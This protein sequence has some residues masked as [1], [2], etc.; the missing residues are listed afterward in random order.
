MSSRWLSLLE[1][2]V[3][4]GVLGLAAVCLVAMLWMYLIRSPN[5]VPYGGRELGPRELAEAIKG[6]A[7]SLEKTFRQPAGQPP[8]VEKFSDRLRKQHDQGIF[9]RGAGQEPALAPELRLAS[10]FGREIVVPGLKE[11]EDAS[12]SI[13]LVTP[14]RPSQLKLRTGRSL[15]VCEQVRITGLE[16]PPAPTPPEESVEAEE[17]AW[18]TV[19]A[20][21]DKK[22]QYDEMIRAGYAPYRSKAYVVGVDAQRQEVLSTGEYSDWSDVRS[23]KA[24]PKFEL[25]EPQFDDQTG[26]LLNKNEIRQTFATVKDAQSTLM[27]P[28]FYAVEGGDFWEFPALAGYE[29]EEEEEEEPED[30]DDRF[31]VVR[32]ASP[33]AAAPPARRTST[34]G[35]S[36]T[37]R[38]GGARGG[39]IRVGPGFRGE[40]GGARTGGYTRSEDDAKKEARKQIRED[41]TE[42]K[43]YLGQKEYD[44]AAQ[45]ANRVIDSQYATKGNIRRAQEILKAA[46]RWLKLQAERE[47]GG[48]GLAR[49]AGVR[50]MPASGGETVE[51][52]AHPETGAPAVW[53][54]DD[55]VEAGKTYRYRMRVKLWNRYVG[56][57][58]A[59]QDPEDAKRTVV[60]GKWSYPSEPVTVTPNT[61]FFFSGGRPPDSASTD[62][63][64]WLKGRWFK[65][66]FD[67]SIGDVIGDMRKI[68]TGEYD[69]EGDE[70]RT[71][72]DFTT[73]VVVLDL[74][75]DER[76]D[77]RWPGKDGRFSYRD[78][79]STVMV[80][81]DP[82]DGQVKEK[83]LIFDRS[84]PK[85]KELEDEAW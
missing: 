72:V 14:L 84:N 24:M 45:T 31:A 64:K 61:Y 70:I 47:E 20:Y 9:A 37:G 76:I 59:A 11:S 58:R 36:R 49:V 39:T 83:V 29:E 33:R 38:V 5:Q 19:A 12:G 10:I 34:G 3:E 53:M 85:K 17:V 21:F 55:T 25:H 63:W 79:K 80:Y 7:D 40:S 26:E 73:G 32:G 8:Q 51:L 65:Q 6:D 15:A 71:E 81:L 43:K 22:A 41:L 52:I 67:V 78:K 16:E 62:V 4:K 54:H 28:P 30:R 13:V 56:R 74:R 77:S 44:L 66:R 1:A 18:V 60:S 23:G 68:K 2:Q 42:A 46:E 35:R 27:Q 75:F 82:A 48:R 57:M 50:G 69:E